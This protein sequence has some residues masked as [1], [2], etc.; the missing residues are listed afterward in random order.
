MKKKIL[1]VLIIIVSLLFIAALTIVGIA[2]GKK[3]KQYNFYKNDE[4]GKNQPSIEY[5]LTILKNDFENEIALALEQNGII[6]SAPKFLNYIKNNHSDFVPLNGKYVVNA[7]MSYAELCQKLQKPDERIEYVKFTVPEGK[8][9]V[10]IAKIVEK[11]GICTKEEFLQA[12]DSYDYDVSF[13][14]ELKD[15]DQSLIGYKLEGYLFPATYE[16]RKDTVTAKEIVEKMLKTFESYLAVSLSDQEGDTIIKRAS[17]MGLSLNELVT[18]GAIIQ[19]EAFSKES[20]ANISSVFWNRYNT[21][22]KQGRKPFPH[23]QSDPTMFY[24][25]A[26][27]ILDKYTKKM[28]DAYDTYVCEGFPVGPTNCPGM[29]VLKAV[30]N[31]ADTNYFYFVTDSNGEFYYN[32]TLQGHNE[33]IRDLKNKNLWG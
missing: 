20:M 31:P 33:T 28:A 9:V 5:T 29:D 3:V 8:T 11:A 15:R 30:I 7:N 18:F 1:T 13:M 25:E 22:D 23:F 16:F 17:E 12:A 19:G 26:L 27:T 14:Q 21:V 32:E 4:L 6:E 24:A 2:V 10:Q